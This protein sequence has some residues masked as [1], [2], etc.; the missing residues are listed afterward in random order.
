MSFPTVNDNGARSQAQNDKNDDS[1]DV[2]AVFEPSANGL[3]ISHRK[4]R[5]HFHEQVMFHFQERPCKSNLE[6]LF[7]LDKGYRL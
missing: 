5:S 1:F 3:L 6:M 7:W 4:L 2:F